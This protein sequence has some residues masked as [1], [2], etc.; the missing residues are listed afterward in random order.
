MNTTSEKKKQTGWVVGES[1]ALELDM[2]LT[3]INGYFFSDWAEGF[4]TLLDS[5]SEDWLAEMQSILAG[6][7]GFISILDYAAIFAGVQFEADYSKATMAIR[8]LSIQGA[9]ERL[10]EMASKYGLSPD[11]SMQVD[12]QLV[13]LALRF[14]IAI[15][16]EIDFYVSLDSPQI[17]YIENGIRHSVQILREGNLHTRFW[18]WLDRFYYEYYRPWRDTRRPFMDELEKKA[19]TMLGS[20][21]N[22]EQ[23][24]DISWLTEKN[25]LINK[26]K[27]NMA[28][29]DGLL[30]VY[31]CVEPF[32]LSDTWGLTPGTVIVTFADPDRITERFSTF[33]EDVAE[34]TKAL[35]DPTRLTILRLIRHLGMVNTEIANYM[36]LARPTVSI[37]AKTLREAGLI[38]SFSEGRMMRHEVVPEEVRRLFR[39]LEKLLDLPPES[40]KD[41]PD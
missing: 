31:F 16:D 22:T 28:V 4:D 20:Y 2:T 13:D 18:H 27:L 34:R 21:Q 23:S 24:P 14:H 38:R 29:Q 26:T 8:D 9:L 40:G 33:V 19:V 17:P 25:P 37:H 35:A 1:I 12:E 6:F 15:Y 11:I 3:G 41:S 10:V 7:K 30:S 5:I 36:G 32:G 39:D